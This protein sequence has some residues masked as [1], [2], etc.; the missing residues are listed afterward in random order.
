LTIQFHL[1]NQRG[2]QEK[3][4]VFQRL[5]VLSCPRWVAFAYLPQVLLALVQ[6]CN[7]LKTDSTLALEGRLVNMAS[8]L[9][10]QPSLF[11]RRLRQPWLD[12][13][14]VD[15]IQRSQVEL[16]NLAAERCHG[17]QL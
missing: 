14:T 16:A 8:G 2:F 11:L 1:R 7:C 4:Q 3:I 13:L 9:E 5:S 10:V 6:C 12:L 17:H 15:A